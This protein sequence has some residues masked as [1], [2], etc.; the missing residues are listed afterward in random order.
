MAGASRTFRGARDEEDPCATCSTPPPVLQLQWTQG[1]SSLPWQAM[2]EWVWLEV[3]ASLESLGFE[4]LMYELMYYLCL[5][6]Q[7]FC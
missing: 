6:H 4:L 1:H 2:G 7:C 5:S 3:S